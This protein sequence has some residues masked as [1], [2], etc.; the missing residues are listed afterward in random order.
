MKALTLLPLL[1][2]LT[3][4]AHPGPYHRRA[5]PSHK[6]T[7][8]PPSSIPGPTFYSGAKPFSVAA[9]PESQKAGARLAGTN[10]TSVSAI[11]AIPAAEMPTA[12]PTA[13]NSAGTYQASY[14]VGID[15]VTSASCGGV[16]LRAGVD[17]F[18]DMGIRQ[19]G[20]WWEWFPA[21]GPV[22]FD[23]AGNFTLVQGDVVRI[24]ATAREDGTGGEV[25]VEKMDGVGCGSK[26]LSTARRGF[27]GM[28]GKDKLCLGEAA[29]V[30]EDYAL[31][32]RPEFLLPL[33]NFTEVVFERIKVNGEGVDAG[34]EVF[35]INLE[36]QGGQLTDCE[37]G[38]DGA[39]VRCKR[40][41][42]GV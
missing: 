31:E 6:L 37:V 23:V 8:V 34:L 24:T 5:L 10:I 14:W 28:S 33:A 11:F 35:D 30:I 7:H 39:S 27:E 2:F 15:G 32:S 17:T 13:G 21:E 12:G 25:V 41:V 4:S 20:A 9:L 29:V 38:A 36:A 3:A 22:F 26:V 1:P 18:W 40:V 16:S 19:T 42:G